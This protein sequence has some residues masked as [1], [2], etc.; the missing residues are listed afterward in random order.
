MIAWCR[1]LVV[2]DREKVRF[3]LEQDIALLAQFRLQSR[4]QMLPALHATSRQMPA[5]NVAVTDEKN[6]PLA[7]EH[8]RAYTQCHAAG[9]PE[10]AMNAPAQQ[11]VIPAQACRFAAIAA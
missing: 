5:R 3:A 10:P 2:I 9:K 8:R 4:A 11:P 1:D 6:A 7:I